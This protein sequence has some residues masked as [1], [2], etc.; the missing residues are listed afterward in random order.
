[1]FG[2]K[3]LDTVG[4]V[5]R[6]VLLI[7]VNRSE[8]GEEVLSPYFRAQG[9]LLMQTLVIYVVAFYNNKKHFILVQEWVAV[10]VASLRF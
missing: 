4:E 9:E 8:V 2:R 10:S 1:V 6:N 3:W 5:V 7:S